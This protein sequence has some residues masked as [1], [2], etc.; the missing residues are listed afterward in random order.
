[1][2]LHN[3]DPVN[4]PIP[5]LGVRIYFGTYPT[6]GND[7]IKFRSRNT[8]IFVTTNELDTTING[9]DTIIHKDLYNIVKH[10]GSLLNKPLLF[11]SYAIQDKGEIC[12]PGNCSSY[13]ASLLNN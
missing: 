10:S 11:R 3:Q 6:N 5:N 1:M 9:K 7:P 8:T 4:N 2:D 13:G 12:P